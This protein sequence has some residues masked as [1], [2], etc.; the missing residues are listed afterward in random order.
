MFSPKVTL[1]DDWVHSVFSCRKDREL[2]RAERVADCEQHVLRSSTWHVD[3]ATVIEDKSADHLQAA[4]EKLH[5]PRPGKEFVRGRMTVSHPPRSPRLVHK[6]GA[7][8]IGHYAPSG[9][10]FQVIV[11][12]R[13]SDPGPCLPPFQNRNR[14]LHRI[15]AARAQVATVQA[16]HP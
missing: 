11:F 9:Q 12:V 3:E 1:E 2:K 16:L 5:A 8:R 14:F 10:L 13:L 15:F 7:L 4:V 6:N